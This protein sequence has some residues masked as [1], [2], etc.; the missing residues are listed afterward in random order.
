MTERARWTTPSE[1]RLQ[2]ERRWKNGDLLRGALTF[3]H[4]LSLR[5]PDAKALRDDFE[6]VREWIRSLESGSKAV[7]GRGY[8][9]LWTE[10]NHR[11]LGRNRLPKAVVFEQ[12]S[13]ALALL[14][15]EKQV[16]QF[17][18]AAQVTLDSF[19]QLAPWLS[20][21]P[22]SLLE[23]EAEW[24]RILKVLHWM[25][26]HPRPGVY[27]R[28]LEIPG[29]DTKF[30]EANRSLLAE[31]LDLIL[32]ANAIQLEAHPLRQ[33]EQRYGL[34]AKPALIRFRC[35]DASVQLGA[36]DDVSTPA[37]QFAQLRLPVTH[38]FV[39]ENEINGLAFPPCPR[40][41]VVFGLGYGLARLAEVPWLR[42]IN[43]YYWG[44][45]DTHGFA[46]LARLREHLPHARSFL[47]DRQ[48]L[49]LHQPLWS[50]EASPYLGEL[51]L[52]TPDEAAL[53]EEIKSERLGVGVRLEQERIAYA[54]VRQA[55]AALGI[56]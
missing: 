41:I 17:E 35:L 4:Q 3:P 51:T 43:L 20:Q 53:F 22:F 40:S 46:M 14:R 54:W 15:V 26:A 19:A 6:A 10:I 16:R 24:P 36:L 44:D 1:L 30:I 55:I 48:T 18:Q 56:S 2:L 33:F 12:R 39:T 32:P 29:V 38:V 28:Q 49:E 5:A 25:K 47:M 45:I 11:Q 27:L 13:D 23:R 8:D 34:N 9:I 31:L 50:V 21:R 42:H 7:L 52:L 37:A